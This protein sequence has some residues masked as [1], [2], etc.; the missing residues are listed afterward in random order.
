MNTVMSMINRCY[1]LVRTVPRQYYLR[2]RLKVAEALLPVVYRREIVF[3]EDIRGHAYDDNEY[4]SKKLRIMAHFIDKTLTL[5]NKRDRSVTVAK[6]SE[7]MRNLCEER[8]SDRTIKHWADRVISCYHN[9]QEISADNVAAI[10]CTGQEALSSIIKTRRS[11]R[12][13][14]GRKIADDV[15]VKILEAGLWAP[16]GCNRQPIEYLVVDDPR[17][18]LLCQQYAGE[19]EG[20]PQEAGVNIVVLVDPR[21][22]ALPHQRHM[23]YLDGGAAIQNIILTAHSLGLGSCW[24]FWGKHGESFNQRYSLARWLLPVSLICIGY[25][26]AHPPIVPQR[27]AVVDSIHDA[28]RDLR[29]ALESWRSASYRTEAQRK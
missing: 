20:F 12:S 8:E 5:S 28:R 10:P 26:D 7:M 18:I 27:K 25:V 19:N 3:F 15:L 24:M 2:V 29:P 21:T 14:T 13:Y 6:A 9:S 1:R 4:A 23:A 17:D 22:Y 11:I 16:S